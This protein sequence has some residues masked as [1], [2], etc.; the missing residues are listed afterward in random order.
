MF[1]AIFVGIVFG[2]HA[3]DIFEEPNL[4]ALYTRIFLRSVD[5]N[6]IALTN[7]NAANKRD[8]VK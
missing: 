2:A 3:R 1:V 8:H 6:C 7:K 4:D 5:E